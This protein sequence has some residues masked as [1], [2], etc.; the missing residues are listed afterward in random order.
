MKFRNK[1]KLYFLNKKLQSLKN[2]LKQTN[3]LLEEKQTLLAELDKKFETTPKTKSDRLNI[4]FLL[5]EIQNCANR[6]NKLEKE[7]NQVVTK[8]GV[9]KYGNQCDCEDC[10]KKRENLLK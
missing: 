1:I 3:Q 2:S 6:A 7:I 9:I 5:C 8:I 10:R 4:E